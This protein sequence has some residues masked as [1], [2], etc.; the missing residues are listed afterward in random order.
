M[1]TPNQSE[2]TLGRKEMLP[3]PPGT[4]QNREDLIQY[5]RDF[6]A[7]HRYVVTIKK[8]RK[9]RRV[10]LGCDRGGAYW[11]KRVDIDGARKCDAVI[12]SGL[13]FSA[14]RPQ[15]QAFKKPSFQSRLSGASPQTRK[16]GSSDYHDVEF[17]DNF[18]SEDDILRAISDAKSKF[19]TSAKNPFVKHCIKLRNDSS[20][21]R[22]HGSVLAVGSTPIREIYRFQESLQ[23]A[24]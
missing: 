14:Y 8:S 24:R 1:D 21:R 4:F 15:P 2:P 7:N 9:D 10:I 16:E 18:G 6:G 22:F 19:I 13:P 23:F 3:P 17:G 11:P 5:V 12:L 20:Y